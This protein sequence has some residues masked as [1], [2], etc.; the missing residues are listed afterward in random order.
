MNHILIKNATI[1]NEGKRFIGNVL[2]EDAF[3][4]KIAAPDEP[5]L[6]LPDQTQI[7]E[8]D[9]KLLLPG[10]I[11][12]QV[13]FRQPGLTHK[14][15]LSSESRAAVAGGVTSVMD[16]PNTIPQTITQDLLNE[17]Y[18]MGAADCLCNYSFFIGATNNNLNELLKTDLDN[19]CGIKVFM[20]SSTGNMMVD[21]PD[22][23][24]QLFKRS[25]ILIATHCED[26]NIIKHNLKLCKDKYG[27]L[28]PFWEHPNIRNA[29]ACFQSTSLAVG[30]A[31]K[32]N[33]RLHVLHLSSSK[34]MDLF[35]N[36]IELKKKRIT[37]EVC[38]PHLW[39]SDKDYERLG[40]KIKW[41][42]AIKT[43]AD[44]QKLWEALLDGRLDI[45]ATDHAP[46]TK[47]EK[48][49]PYLKAPSGGPMIQHSLVL[50]L[51]CAAKGLISIEKVVG[52]MCHAPAEVFNIEKR[53]YLRE[54]YYADMTLVEEKKWTVTPQSLL[55]RCG[56]SPLEGQEFGSQ[57]AQTFVNGNLV[58]DNGM[59]IDNHKGMRLRFHRNEE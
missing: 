44:Q 28:I 38:V 35:D 57:V 34:E 41:N 58:Y 56:W 48:N 11:D 19:V 39:F 45:I 23:L 40:S 17:K 21:D 27:D 4:K 47:E 49:N 13:H 37:A 54:G 15:D 9:Y 24:E 42:P 6:S 55:Y 22:S 51:E 50:M 59:I 5:L 20:G 46:H 31:R 3:I 32:Y 36:H 16:M 25:K 10:V 26:E 2:I 18:R 1:I 53:G 14:G 43:L 33:S 52:K 8:A 30:L 29:E 7:I 12:D